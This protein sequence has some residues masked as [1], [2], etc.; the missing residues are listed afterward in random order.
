MIDLK[1]IYGDARGNLC[2]LEWRGQEVLLFS[3][4]K[5]Y[6]RGGDYHKSR[7]H[8]VVLAGRVECRFKRHIESQGEV[9]KTLNPGEV[10][11]FEAGSPHMFT[12]LE[13][14]LMVEWLEGPFEK[15]MYPPYRKIVEEKMK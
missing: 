9:V 4:N 5:G 12:A 11:S 7:Q 13:D 2:I 8:D 6:S 3:I 14:S 15:E 1:E 10:I